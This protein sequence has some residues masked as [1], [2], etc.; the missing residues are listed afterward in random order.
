MLRSRVWGLEF[1]VRVGRLWLG[2]FDHFGGSSVVER[3]PTPMQQV[4]SKL[5]LGNSP[6]TANGV[7]DPWNPR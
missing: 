4:A 3:F 5:H 6:F 1:K 7:L 2:F